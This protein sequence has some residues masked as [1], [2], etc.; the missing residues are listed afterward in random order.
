MRPRVVLAL[1]LPS[2]AAAVGWWLYQDR[3]ATAL[4]WGLGLLLGW[5]LSRSRLCIVAAFRDSILFG[6][7]GPAMAV[8]LALALSLPGFAF[9][10]ASI[11]GQGGP[12]PGSLSPVGPLTLVGAV[13]FGIGSVPAGG[14]A[15]TTLVRIGEGHVRFLFTLV[16][17]L[18]GA[19]LGAYQYGWW[20]GLTG[21]LDP[22]HLP[23]VLGWPGALVAEGLLLGLLG[24]LLRWW[25]RRGMER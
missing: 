8:L 24:L 5:A 19:L 18:A 4:L 9:V 7:T 21:A 11:I 25:S 14:C 13:L 6:D 2:A 22:V 16:G 10:Q 12:L 3:P 17:L 15:I 23:G 20:V 1:V